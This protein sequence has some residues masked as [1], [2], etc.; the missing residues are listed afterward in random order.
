MGVDYL[1][2]GRGVVGSIIAGVGIVGCVVGLAADLYRGVRLGASR[3]SE[4]LAEQAAQQVLTAARERERVMRSRNEVR[5]TAMRADRGTDP[6]LTER[7]PP[8]PEP[9]A[10]AQDAAF[11]GGCLFVV[12]MVVLM[13]GL[14]GT[15]VILAKQDAS[16]SQ[17]PIGI[18]AAVSTV[19][20]AAVLFGMAAIVKL[21]GEACSLLRR[22]DKRA[23]DQ[24]RSRGE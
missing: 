2:A 9:A 13:L 6:P 17:V 3:V 20:T 22:A 8:S 10:S 11:A 1:T 12:G 15:M 4:S 24:S 5:E 7:Q 19:I 14:L 21:L 23:A 18:A 16:Q